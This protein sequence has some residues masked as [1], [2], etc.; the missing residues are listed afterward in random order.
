MEKIIEKEDMDQAGGGSGVN[1]DFLGVDYDCDEATSFGKQS[2][3][4]N[5]KGLTTYHVHFK[6]SSVVSKSSSSLK[7]NRIRRFSEQFHKPADFCLK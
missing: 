4:S 6:D 7:S 2:K 5:S 1:G 3:R